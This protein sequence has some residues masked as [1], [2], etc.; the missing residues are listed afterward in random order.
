MKKLIVI[1]FLLPVV[2]IGQDLPQE[3][4]FVKNLDLSQWNKIVAKATKEDKIIFIQFGFSEFNDEYL[5][6]LKTVYNEKSIADYLKEHF[7]CL[8]IPVKDRFKQVLPPN[9]FLDSLMPLPEVG[10]IVF[11]I[12][13]TKQGKRL[14][15]RSGTPTNANNFLEELQDV[16]NGKDNYHQMIEEFNNGNRDIEFFKHL[17]PT[18]IKVSDKV[19]NY[20]KV[21]IQTRNNL[22]TK[23]NAELLMHCYSQNLAFDYLYNNQDL[24]GKVISV[25]TL[26]N[27]YKKEISKQIQIRYYNVNIINPYDLI[28]KFDEKYPKYGRYE[29][30]KFLLVQ[31]PIYLNAK[32]S[33]NY[34]YIINNYVDS[35]FLSKS[36]AADFNIYAWRTFQKITDTTLFNKALSWSKKSLEQD[37]DNPMYLDTY[38]NLLYKLGQVNEA[39]ELET[40]ALKLIEE[41]NKKS[42]QEVLDKM[43]KGEPTW[44]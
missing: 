10:Q 32:N 17:L 18:V 12:F 40:K 14:H 41:K 13:F 25:D 29:S 6:K 3:I 31:Q 42:Y 15:K 16:V 9:P 27:F 4:V 33:I 36:N 34:D 44:K 19:D 20:L 1:M 5:N 38:A 30:I 39:I 22:F 8:S 28:R 21:F 23:E 43:K 2:V 24:W 11:S 37:K 35:S 26:E 7:I